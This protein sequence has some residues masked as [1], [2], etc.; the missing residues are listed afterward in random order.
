MRFPVV[1]D[2]CVELVVYVQLLARTDPEEAPKKQRR[3]MPEDPRPKSWSLRGTERPENQA[4][5]NENDADVVSEA[6]AAGRQGE[7]R[8]GPA[9][10]LKQVTCAD[11][12]DECEQ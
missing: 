4:G 9:A 8:P 10:L 11:H 5:Q 2:P 6:K 3:D 12:E 7:E 1:G